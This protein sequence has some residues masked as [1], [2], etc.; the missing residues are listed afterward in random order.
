MSRDDRAYQLALAR[1]LQAG[2]RSAEAQELLADLLRRQPTDGEA[3]LLMARVLGRARRQRRCGGLLPP[4]RL[5]ALARPRRRT[6]AAGPGRARRPARCP[7]RTRSAGG[8]AHPAEGAGDQP[9]RGARRRRGGGTG[10]PR[11]PGGGR[12][13]RGGGRRR[14]RTT[15][16]STARLALARGLSAIDPAAPALKAWDRYARS[17]ALLDLVRDDAAACQEAAEVAAEAWT[18]VGPAWRHQ[19]AARRGRQ[20]GAR[21]AAV[22]GE[23]VALSDARRA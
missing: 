6:A 4:R 23:D 18:G 10:A 17:V 1:A 5:R 22:E 20:P 16:I 15:P 12:R 14:L 21:G 11:L 13:F 7:R 2:G 9:S 19:S 8:R 3:S